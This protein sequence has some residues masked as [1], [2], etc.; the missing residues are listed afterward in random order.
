MHNPSRFRQMGW[1]ALFPLLM[2]FLGLASPAQATPLPLSISIDQP[3]RT[4]LP[5][6]TV[7]FTGTITNNSGNDLDAASDL[8]LNFT[9]FDTTALSFTQVLGN[10]DFSLPN[11]ATSPDVELFD[12][13]LDLSATPAGSPYLADVTVSDSLGDVSDPVTISITAV[14]EPGSL[15]LALAALIIMIG[16]VKRRTGV[17]WFSRALV[18]GLAIMA[19]VITTPGHAAVTPVSL[20]APNAATSVWAGTTTV[21]VE[22]QIANNGTADAG[23]VVVK[24]VSVQGGS[25]SASSPAL[26]IVLGPINAGD[27]APLDLVI[28]A[29]MGV[30][31]TTRYLVTVN[32]TYT[33][34]PTTYGFSIN[35]ALF[36]NATGPGPISPVGGTTIINVPP[37]TGVT[38]PPTPT[39]PNFGPNAETPNLVP[40]GPPT[41]G[42]PPITSPGSSL[43]SLTPGGSVI[44]PVNNGRALGAGTP[45]DPNAAASPDGVVLSTYNTGISYS[46]NGGTTFTDVNLFNPI[47]G[48]T[49]FFP[50]SDGGLCCDQVVVFIPDPNRPLFVWLQQY[51]P[52][53]ACATNCRPP[54]AMNA[55]YKIT[56]PNRLRVAWATPADIKAN[57]N[58]AWTY[59]DLTATST[60]GVSSGLGTKNNEWMDYPDL[61]WSGTFLYVGVDH[62]STTPGSVYTGKR[63][64]A[65]LS[66]AD[67]RNT[68]ATVVH[69]DYAE[70]SGSSGLNKD[71]FVQ[72]APNRMVVG[73]LDNSSTFRVFTWDDGSGSIGNTTVGLNNQIKQGASYTSIAPDNTDWVAVSFPGNITGAVYRSVIPGIGIRPRRRKTST[74]LPSTPG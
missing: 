48:R 23:N 65:R 46:T 14:P 43:G 22:F 74:S 24:S 17:R 16:L 8:F 21:G 57:F 10:P 41:S 40:I 67:L 34:G 3:D 4:A 15:P 11:G 62:G 54:P 73:S 51:W 69:Y 33:Y 2:V 13:L 26:P 61:A 70:L 50:Q 39:P 37:Y 36:P 60:A 45:P 7:V 35:R 12:A 9:G 71:H 6:S 28:N 55:T 5:G 1:A 64:V 66:L 68:A 63:I 25:V 72:Q 29:P 38:F 27:S 32:G 53:T 52:Q 18:P 20:Y 31:G 56:Q 59:A 44:I 42:L 49:S 30:N 58:N 47:A 19:A